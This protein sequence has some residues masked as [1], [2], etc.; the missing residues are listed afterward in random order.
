MTASTAKIGLGAALWMGDGGSPET[1]TQVANVVSIDGPSET[2]ETVDVTH[3]QST[4]GYREYLPHLKDG[5]EV[6]VTTHYDP[7]HATH[8]GTTGL[9][10][11]YDDRSLVNFKFD[12]SQQFAT[13]GVINFSAYVTALSKGAQV[14]QALEQ[15]VTLR[16]TGAPVLSNTVVQQ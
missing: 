15:Q 10:K 13:N 6:T 2:M 8:D 1:F 3:L 12:M 16:I 9:K 11:K 14:D 7:T 4:G 5:G